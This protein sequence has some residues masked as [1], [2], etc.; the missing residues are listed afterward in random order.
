MKRKHFRVE[1][2]YQLVRVTLGHTAMDEWLKEQDK[3]KRIELPLWFAISQLRPAKRGTRRR[4]ML[5]P[6]QSVTSEAAFDGKFQAGSVSSAENMQTV[7]MPALIATSQ[8]HYSTRSIIGLLA[9]A[10]VL[11]HAVVKVSTG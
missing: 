7:N 6:G 11:Q 9:P 3:S 10:S 4:A 2:D 8:A 5:K 1:L